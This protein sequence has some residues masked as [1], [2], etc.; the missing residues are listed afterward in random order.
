MPRG[1]TAETAEAPGDRP[2]E[3]ERH[4]LERARRPAAGARLHRPARDWR[5]RLGVLGP[6][7][8]LPR[9][10]PRVAAA[11]LRFVNL[12]ARGGWD[13]DQGTEMLAL[14]SALAAGRL[15]T[16]G[17]EA[18][19]VA[20]SF[21]HGA[22]YYDLLLPAAWLGNGD[23]TWVVGGD[24]PAEPGRGPDRLVDRPVDRR[25]GGRPDGRLPGRGVGQPDRLRHVHL[26]PHAGRARRR[27]CLPGRVAGPPDASRR[28]VDRGRGRVRG[29]GPE[30]TSPRP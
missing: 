16:F 28:L 6:R 9:G 7:T 3:S 13:S 15:P 18:I 14:R 19:S 8:G 5:D 29:R 27:G 12:P 25:T 30:R 17:P 22:L 23:P 1:C 24:R 26:E 2:A 10:D 11:V 21:H 20:S 4:G